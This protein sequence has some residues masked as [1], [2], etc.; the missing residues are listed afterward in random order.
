MIP[1]TGNPLD[2]ASDRRSDLEWIAAR[3]RDAGSLVLPVWRLQ[4][5]FLGPESA[6]DG[7][8]AGF[9]K[10]GLAE[11]LAAPDA[12]WVFLGLEGP[13]AV[14]AIDISAAPDPANEGALAG[15]GHF[16]DLR[17]AAPM[18]PA[19][20]LAILGQAKAL[21]DW[22]ARHRYCANCGA[23]TSLVDGG[24]RRAC[25]TCG[26]EHFPRTDPVVI[27]LATHGEACF[28]G[29][30]PHFPAGWYSALA[31]FMEPG[32]TIE[33]AVCRELREEAGLDISV[34][35]YYATQPWPFPSSLMIGCFAEA[36]SREFVIDG[37][38]VV[39]ARWLD[40][41]DARKLLAGERIEGVRIPPGIAIAHH[42]IKAWA[43]R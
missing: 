37:R 14:F 26:A 28:I 36:R 23:A 31:G 40:R 25:E 24:Y 12:P 38:E 42:L 21:I 27:M 29:R 6:R 18:L 13:H 34:V 5:F 33:E 20:D 41:T 8:E 43:E 3:K 35:T 16:R 1:F 32:E 11:S 17:Q 15:L 9:L 19:K 10:P 4:P 2:R 7:L 30:G 39:D 22:H